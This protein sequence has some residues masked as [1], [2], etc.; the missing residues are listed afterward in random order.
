MNTTPIKVSVIIPVFNAGKYVRE[1]IDSVLAQDV[2]VEIIAVDDASM[3]N[4]LSILES[5]GDRITVL[6]RLENGGIGVARNDGLSV[7][8]GD[9][10]AFL[11][12]DDI[13][14]PG[15]LVAQLAQFTANPALGISFGHLECF[16]S[17]ELSPEDAALRHCPQG[18]LPGYIAGSAV[19]RADILRTVG[20]FDPR[21]R[22]G[23]FIDWLARAKAAGCVIDILP[24]VLLR[25][26]IH[27]T[28][29]GIVDR[30][31][32]AQYA[33]ILKDAL[34]RKRRK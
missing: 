12:A 4:S 16:I 1:A 28:N 2:A 5:Y 15:K 19:M 31:K 6:R 33:Q 3:D 20:L 18:P 17:P 26:R 29:T 7:A 13:W 22:V 14:T 30:A 21:W 27:T 10:I 8:R 32:R 11:D 9:F 25:R 23:E 24:E 34:D